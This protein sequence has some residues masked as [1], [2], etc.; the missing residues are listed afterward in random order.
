MTSVFRPDDVLAGFH[1]V[2]PDGEE[3]GLVHAGEQWVPTSLVIGEH[4]HRVWELYLQTRGASHWRLGTRE[5]RLASGHFLA[6]PPGVA[7]TM[8]GRPSAS[9]HFAYAGVALAAVCRRHPALARPWTLP[10]P[11][12]VPGAESLQ[13]PFRQLVREAGMRLPYRREGFVIAVDHLVVAAT[14]L[15]SSSP[16]GTPIVAV[17]P[18]VQAARRLL[19]EHYDRPLPLADLARAT[20]LSANY[21]VELFTREV[22]LP[23]H[24]Y[25]L[26]RRID[27]AKELLDHADLP[28]T[29]IAHELGYA[30]GQH[31]ARS[32]RQGVGCSPSEFRRR[33]QTVPSPGPDVAQLQT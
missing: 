15:I 4:A 22:G 18:A 29:R 19:D 2:F 14:R 8:V 23:P 31:F 26:E 28:I 16:T 11:F 24:R 7:H 33:F 32:F 27:R 21:L 5:Y 17:H 13:V 20:G 30:S 10:R 1:A 25:L 6:V 12:H 9:H 3:T